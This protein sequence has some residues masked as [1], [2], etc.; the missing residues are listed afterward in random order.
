VVVAPVGKT[1]DVAGG[2]TV[3]LERATGRNATVEPV[4]GQALDRQTGRT[5]DGLEAG[6]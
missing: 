3:N 1:P 6:R 4:A 5:L 2:S